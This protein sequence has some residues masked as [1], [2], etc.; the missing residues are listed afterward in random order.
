M[1]I[2]E[3]LRQVLALRSVK[4]MGPRAFANGLLAFG[5]LEGFFQNS[6]KNWTRVE[7]LRRLDPAGLGTKEC[8]KAVDVEIETAVAQKTNIVTFLDKEYPALLKEIHDPPIVLYVKGALPENSSVCLAMVGSRA[9]SRHGVETAVSLAKDLAGAGAVIVSGLALGID[10]AS[11]RGALQTGRT[12]AVLGSGV[13]KIYPSENRKLADEISGHGAVISEFP[14][15]TGP[16]PQYFPMRNRII[17]GLSR[18]VIVVEARQKS[19]AL[20]TV[21]FALEQGR[22]VYALPAYADSKKAEGSNELLKQGARFVTS[23]EDILNDFHLKKRLSRSGAPKGR[24]ALE[25]EEKDLVR[26]LRD[27]EAMHLDELVEK[28]DLSPQ[29]AM[30]LLTSLALKGAVRELPG[31]YFMEG[32][33]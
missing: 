21:D 7:G 33:S 12:V 27:V 9:A 31:K 6:A 3:R 15:E 14:M 23:A 30:T 19:G 20:I 32:A 18:A 5:S 26:L 24:A 13:S 2:T 17:S 1:R 4:N 16:L 10:S 25:G 22:D 11:H 28:T 29:K 8:W